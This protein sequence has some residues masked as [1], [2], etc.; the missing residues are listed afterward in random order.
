MYKTEYLIILLYFIYRCLMRFP[1]TTIRL[2]F[3]SLIDEMAPPP[4]LQ[5]TLIQTQT[6]S[7]V[8]PSRSYANPLSI[9]IPPQVV[10]QESTYLTKE[11]R[12]MSPFPSPTGTLRLVL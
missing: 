9:N 1:S 10:K 7:I 4:I 11:N 2:V 5:N 8:T 3:Y 12:F 6:R